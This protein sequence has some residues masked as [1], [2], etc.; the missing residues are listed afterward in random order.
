MGLLL[1]SNKTKIQ[2][3]IR[4]RK[5]IFLILNNQHIQDGL[6]QGSGPYG[7]ESEGA[8]DS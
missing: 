1:N 2:A 8:Q 3:R 7:A 5:I 4:Y 6:S